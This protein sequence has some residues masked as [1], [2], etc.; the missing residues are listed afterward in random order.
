MHARGRPCDCELFR[1]LIRPGLFALV[2]R[3]LPLAALALLP[4]GAAAQ[5]DPFPSRPIR[6]IAS[7]SPGGVTDLLSRTLGQLLTES[8]GQAVVIDNRPGAGTLIGMSACA[9]APADGYTLCITDNQ[10][11]VYNPLLFNKLPYDP[12][13][14]FVSVGGVVR[15]VGDVI[16]AHTSLP[17]NNFQELLAYTKTNPGAVSFATWG[18]GSIPAIYYA[19]ITRQNGVQLTAVPYKG[20]GPS[21]RAVMGGEVQLAYSNAAIAKPAIDSGRV[22]IIAVAGNSRRP[23]LPNIASLGESKSDPGISTFWGLYAP[24]KTP[25]AVIQR[26]N[27]ELNKALRSPRFQAF[28]AQSSLEPIPSSPEEFAN[29]LAQ[30]Q[31]HAARTFNLIGIKPVDAPTDT[32]ELAKP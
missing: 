21:F 28:A 6:I 26:L 18:P 24:A 7:T 25:A 5:A 29:Y 10:S 1:M 27:N 16:L 22:K 8:T 13:A 4:L 15:G 20:A 2:F 12:K 17:A 19:W 32:P 11:L 31:A 30:T 3:T 9:K 14:D 23:E